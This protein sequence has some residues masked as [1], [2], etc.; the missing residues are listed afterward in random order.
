MK[1]NNNENLGSTFTS[2]LREATLEARKKALKRRELNQPCVDSYKR[3][4]IEIVKVYDFD[5]ERFRTEWLLHKQELEELI[6]KPSKISATIN[7]E[8]VYCEVSFKYKNDKDMPIYLNQELDKD[9]I[10]KM[11]EEDG[12]RRLLI[13]SDKVF[14]I[15]F[16]ANIIVEH[17]KDYN[18]AA[19][20]KVKTINK[21]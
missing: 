5:I 1:N 4:I 8:S 9:L 12:L 2:E 20:Q 18:E 10:T 6:G 11:L 16:P 7:K 14:V 3:I 13:P 17:Q 19:K 15:A 21:Q